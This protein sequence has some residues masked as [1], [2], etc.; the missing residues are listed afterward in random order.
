M[1]PRLTRLG[2]VIKYARRVNR[3]I[4]SMAQLPAKKR[5]VAT[6]FT[7]EQFRAITQ[8]AEKCGVHLSVWMRSILM[9]CTRRPSREG[10]IR[11]RLPDGGLT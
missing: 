5:L 1:R 11:V 8:S 9:Q 3:S 2:D 4:A 7:P 6:K 10:Y